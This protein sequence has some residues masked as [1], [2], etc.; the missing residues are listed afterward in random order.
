MI[1]ST[2]VC[3]S[4]PETM[5]RQLR[6]DAFESDI[7]LRCC[8][9]TLFKGKLLQQFHNPLRQWDCPNRSLVLCG[10]WSD[11]HRPELQIEIFTLPV[12]DLANPRTAIDLNQDG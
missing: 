8:T 11:L 4:V 2:Q 5:G 6:I 1:A 12:S 10:A 9:P 7:E 3:D